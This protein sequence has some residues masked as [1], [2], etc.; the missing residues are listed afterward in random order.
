M[1]WQGSISLSFPIFYVDND[2]EALKELVQKNVSWV[3]KLYPKRLTNSQLIVIMVFIFYFTKQSNTSLVNYQGLY[4]PI[5]SELLDNRHSNVYQFFKFHSKVSTTARNMNMPW[6][7]H[8]KISI[9]ALLLLKN[10][11]FNNVL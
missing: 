2:F 5:F 7:C 10:V 3:V 4:S 1:S 11:V 8:F 9:C 6:L